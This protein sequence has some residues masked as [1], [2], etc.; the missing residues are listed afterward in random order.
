[1]L[2]ILVQDGLLADAWLAEHANGLDELVAHLRTIDVAESCAKAGVD[3]ADVRRAAHAIGNA[4][5]G[6]SVLEDLGIQMAPHSTLNSY[7]EKLL[8]LLTGN[9]GVPGGVNIHSHFVALLGGGADS[10]GQTDARHR[11]PAGDR[12]S[13]R[14]T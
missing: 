11:P 13:C 4:T 8:V 1:M 7:L 3:E 9:L 2:A 14:A 5:G 12:V 6:V 10:R